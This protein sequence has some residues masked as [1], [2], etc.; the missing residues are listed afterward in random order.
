MDIQAAAKASWEKK[1]LSKLKI[2]SYPDTTARLKIFIFLQWQ[3]HNDY[4]W[5]QAYGDYPVVGVNWKQA[6][7]CMENFKHLC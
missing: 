2:L 4:F 6:K 7:F 3:S 5:H 1:N